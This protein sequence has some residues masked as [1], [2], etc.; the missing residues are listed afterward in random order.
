MAVSHWE[1]IT[2]GNGLCVAW[3]AYVLVACVACH[4]RQWYAV[5]HEDSLYGLCDDGGVIRGWRG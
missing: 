5:V 1:E 2:L 4:T 3:L